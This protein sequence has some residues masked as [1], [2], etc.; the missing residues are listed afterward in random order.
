MNGLLPESTPVLLLGGGG[1]AKVLLDVLLRLGASILGYSDSDHE[2][3]DLLGIPRLG[4]DEAISRFSSSDIALVIAIGSTRASSVRRDV[5]E[6]FK[7]EGYVYRSVIHPSAVIADSVVMG[8][9]V[10]VMAGAVVQPGCTIGDN[11]LINTR[12]SVDHD[13]VIGSHV[14]VAPGVT[15]S[16]GVWLS[17]G[18]HVGTGACVIQGVRIGESSTVGAGAVVLYDV[19]DHATVIGIPARVL[20]K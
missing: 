12:A 10:Q 4:G 16:G 15:L 3:S 17:D 9:G 7:K 19:P 11:S 5:F 1:H 20:R 14:H 13:C 8:E 6:R 18:V 2:K